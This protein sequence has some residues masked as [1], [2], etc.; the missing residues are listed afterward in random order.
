MPRE[1]RIP[2]QQT[3]PDEPRNPARRD[4]LGRTVAL[5]TGFLGGT[6][7]GRFGFGG[8]AGAETLLTTVTQNPNAAKEAKAATAA[9]SSAIEFQQVLNQEDLFARFQD[10]AENLAANSPIWRHPNPATIKRV[11]EAPFLPATEKEVQDYGAAHGWDRAVFNRVIMLPSDH[12]LDHRTDWKKAVFNLG[13]A[14]GWGDIT[15]WEN[16]WVYEM[17]LTAGLNDIMANNQVKVMSNGQMVDIDPIRVDNGTVAM[18]IVDRGNPKMSVYMVPWVAGE[19]HARL[20]QDTEASEITMG[21]ALNQHYTQFKTE[22]GALSGAKGAGQQ[23]QSADVPAIIVRAVSTA[24]V[25]VI[26]GRPTDDNGG[27][28]L[29]AVDTIKRESDGKDVPLELEPL[30]GNITVHLPKDGVRNEHAPFILIR[31]PVVAN[32]LKGETEVIFVPGVDLLP[33]DPKWAPKHRVTEDML[34]AGRLIA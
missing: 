18:N 15:A 26:Y 32:S 10:L 25:T 33:S 16:T 27:Y 13:Q 3:E 14:R 28:E 8:A 19:V 30:T 4:F 22:G 11:K 29:R 31:I 34:K 24:P 6:L 12:P 17:M 1:R 5:G 20:P 21:F 2:G 23:A 9:S 7:V